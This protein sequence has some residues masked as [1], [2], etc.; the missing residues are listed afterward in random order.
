MNPPRLPLSGH[1]S[2]RLPE[3]LRKISATGGVINL[4]A[5]QAIMRE[6]TDGD[7]PALSAKDNYKARIS[8]LR[9]GG[10]LN[11][12]SLLNKKT[13]FDD[14][15]IASSSG[16]A[17]LLNRLSKNAPLQLSSLFTP[18]TAA[19]CCRFC[20]RSLLRHSGIARDNWLVP[21]RTSASRLAVESGSRLPQSRVLRTDEPRERPSDVS[22]YPNFSPHRLRFRLETALGWRCVV[23]VVQ[24]A[25]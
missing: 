17:M 19:A 7:S 9:S 5:L 24:S 16:I 3:D 25:Q 6:W 8:H 4:A 2:I 15:D 11:G 23:A 20:V 13:V 18:W 22:S 21:R 12:T 14:D 1:Q 10:G